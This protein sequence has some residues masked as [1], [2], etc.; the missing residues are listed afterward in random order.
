MV[1]RS[2]VN[3][4]EHWFIWLL[5]TGYLNVT[6]C[7]FLEKRKL[8][9]LWILFTLSSLPG[10]SKF[11]ILFFEYFIDPDWNYSQ[12]RIYWIELYIYIY[13]CIQISLN[14]IDIFCLHIFL[15]IRS[16]C[17]I[18]FIVF[19]NTNW[20]TRKYLLC[21]TKFV[22]MKKCCQYIYIY[23]YIYIYCSRKNFVFLFG[24]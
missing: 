2:P 3:F 21:S 12:I 16:Y 23:I 7:W 1:W 8:F 15:L 9:A 17:R 19:G 18:T 5:L 11:N 24:A 22:L 4:L 14:I 6:G 10:S 20:S 13:I